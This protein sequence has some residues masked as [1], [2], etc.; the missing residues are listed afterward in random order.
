ML[1]GTTAIVT[2]GGTG[3]GAAVAQVLAGAGAQVVICGRRADALHAVAE[4]IKGDRPVRARTCDVAERR[5]VQA[6]VDETVADFGRL[7]LVVSSAGVNIPARRLDLLA[8]DDWDALLAVNT[9][10]VFN[11]VQAALPTMRARGG[12]L[13]ITISSIAGLRPT[14]GAGA[15][16]AASKSGVTALMRVLAQEEAASGIRASV[17]SPGEVDTPLLDKRPAP[18]SAAHRARVLQPEDVAAAV[19]F[20]ASLPPRASVPELVITPTVIPFF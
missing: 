20:V 10:G 3:V 18:P 13:F 11:I 15:A 17:I 14:E 19:L 1:E 4:S 12:G 9:T 8:P 6:L 7:N 16:Y 5:Q 2:G